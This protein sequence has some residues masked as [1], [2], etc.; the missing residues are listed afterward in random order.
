MIT[1]TWRPSPHAVG[2]AVGVWPDLNEPATWYQEDGAPM[3]IGAV[4]TTRDGASFTTTYAYCGESGQPACS[5]VGDP[6]YTSNVLDYGNPT[7]VRETSTVMAADWVTRYT[8]R[9]DFGSRYVRGRVASQTLE[10]GARATRAARST[11]TRG[12]G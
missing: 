9:D 8:Y 7:F 4:T 12:S 10:S 2:E 5:N 11:T 3:L 1:Y 6:L